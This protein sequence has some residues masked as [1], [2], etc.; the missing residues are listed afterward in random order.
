MSNY[1]G[2]DA[3]AAL[4]DYLHHAKEISD[5]LGRL[6]AEILHFVALKLEIFEKYPELLPRN[7]RSLQREWVKRGGYLYNVAKMYIAVSERLGVLRRREGRMLRARLQC[8]QLERNMR[9]EITMEAEAAEEMRLER[10][11]MA[12]N[13]WKWTQ[14]G[15]NEKKGENQEGNKKEGEN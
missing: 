3:Y 8:I 12:R 7:R 14:H 10:M 4:R 15:K 11:E 2:P 6:R 13:E 1:I 9:R 5:D